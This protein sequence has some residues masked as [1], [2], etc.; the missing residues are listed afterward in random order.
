MS[1][2]RSQLTARKKKTGSANE[3]NMWCFD[4]LGHTA[5]MVGFVTNVS[6]S[7]GSFI[8]RGKKRKEN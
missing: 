3:V 4:V 6:H 1:R 7:I 5:G 8:C 2:P